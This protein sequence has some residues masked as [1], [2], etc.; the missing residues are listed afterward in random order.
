V[1]E[2]LAPEG[3]GAVEGP[4]PPVSGEWPAGT[5]DLEAE[6]T[7]F[8]FEPTPARAA[9]AARSRGWRLGGAIRIFVVFVV[10][11]P[12]VAIF[13][14]HAVWLIGALLTG[15]V[16]ARRRY[17]ERFTLLGVE[18]TCP[19]CGAPYSVKRSRLRVPHPLA[20]ETCHH[21]GSLRLPSGTLEAH[22]SE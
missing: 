12:F 1:P 18:G 15:A 11:A 3:S 4:G 20:C 7:L 5:H 21:E 16:L 10:A 19:K 9:I 14:P 22:A 8:G 13:P 2:R 6:A 17:I